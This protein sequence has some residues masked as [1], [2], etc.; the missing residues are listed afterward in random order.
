MK[1]SGIEKITCLCVC[2]K[3]SFV[4]CEGEGVL[5]FDILFW[6][7]LEHFLC[8]AISKDAADGHSRIRTLDPPFVK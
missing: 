1:S 5:A 2:W 7:E 3:S 6:F 4:N 8:L